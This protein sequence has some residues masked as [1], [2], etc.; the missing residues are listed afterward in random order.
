MEGIRSKDRVQKFGEVFTPEQTVK[1]MLDMLPSNFDFLR[2]TVL[3]PSCGDGNFLV[4]ILKRKLNL[5]FE[6]TDINILNCVS[7]IYAI[8][9]QA[10]NV[11]DSRKRLLGVVEDFCAENN[12]IISKELKH[13]IELILQWNIILGD[14]IEDKYI[15]MDNEG[16]AYNYETNERHSLNVKIVKDDGS[17]LDISDMFKTN[18]K[19]DKFGCI[20][21]RVWNTSDMTFSTEVLKEEKYVEVKSASEY[22]SE[23]VN[24]F[25]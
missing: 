4:E 15:K 14:F 18:K 2:E 12:Y 11:L 6:I 16:Y 17:R 8:D 5:L 13:N 7:T 23:F 20:T 1:D 22:L 21:F 25:S 3:E 9:I 10:D 24:M 19:T